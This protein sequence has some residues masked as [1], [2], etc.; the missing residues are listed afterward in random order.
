MGG[1]GFIFEPSASS[2]ALNPL[3]AALTLCYHD[4]W[5]LLGTYLGPR[6]DIFG[7]YYMTHGTYFSLL[8]PNHTNRPLQSAGSW[9]PC[10]E[11]WWITFLSVLGIS[12]CQPECY[13][14]SAFKAWVTFWPLIKILLSAA[15]HCS[16]HISKHNEIK[17][18]IYLFRYLLS[19][20]LTYLDL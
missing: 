16:P 14:I 19:K 12:H 11:Q 2:V 3:S 17:E 20:H 10:F 4:T 8:A 18:I 5:D 15:Q 6:W 13:Y 9:E 1:Q 7:T